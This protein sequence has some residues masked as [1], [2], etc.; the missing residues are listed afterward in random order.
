M[1]NNTHRDSASAPFDNCSFPPPDF[2]KITG[3]E[4]LSMILIER[5]AEINR[6]LRSNA[7]LAAIILMGGI[8]EAVFLAIVKKFPKKARECKSAPLDKKGKIKKIRDWT[9]NDLIN[10]AYDCD[11]IHQDAAKFGHLLRKYRNL[12]HPWEQLTSENETPSK[13][14]CSECWQTVRSSLYDLENLEKPD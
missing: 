12:V 2:L 8:L 6:C 1:D 10:V 5:W 7:H 9:L 3:D 13:E 4:N 14:D 11:W